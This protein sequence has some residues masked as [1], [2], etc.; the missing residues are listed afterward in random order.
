LNTRFL[1]FFSISKS[2]SNPCPS[3][4]IYIIW[5]YLYQLIIYPL[6]FYRFSSLSFGQ[7]CREIILYFLG[8]H[9]RSHA[10][11]EMCPEAYLIYPR[12]ILR[13]ASAR[14]KPNYWIEFRSFSQNIVHPLDII[15]IIYPSKVSDQFY[16]SKETKT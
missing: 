7:F 16:C 13:I 2:Q 8:H 3:D 1:I 10:I 12:I 11:L 6:V 9:K 15:Y 4:V 14:E 5:V